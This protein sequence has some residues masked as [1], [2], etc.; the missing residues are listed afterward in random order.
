MS[1][2]SNQAKISEMLKMDGDFLHGPQPRWQKK[3]QEKGV[4][5]LSLNE[6]SKYLLHHFRY[7]R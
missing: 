6:N 4:S 3:A 2:L 5:V 1:H 7:N